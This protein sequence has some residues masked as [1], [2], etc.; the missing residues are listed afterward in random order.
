MGYI[1]IWNP[2]S[3][4]SHIHTNDRGFIEHFNEREDAI[5]EAKECRDREHYRDFILYEEDIFKLPKD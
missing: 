1:I 5:T 2:T 3:S 4:D